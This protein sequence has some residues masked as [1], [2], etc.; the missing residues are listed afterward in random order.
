MNRAL[1]LLMALQGRGWLR[2]AGRSVRT[3]KG[4]VLVLVGL[5]VFAPW[6]LSVFLLPQPERS[7]VAPEDL[8]RYGPAVFLV[9]CLSTV[10]F[11]R[12]ERALYFSPAEV[13][14]LFCGPYTRRQLLAYKVVASTLVG[15]PT[16]LF[17]SLL[18]QVHARWYVAAFVGLFLTYLFF[19]LF[20]L[21]VNI[22]GITV[23]ARAYSAGRRV[24]L[25]G[26][27]LVLAVVLF[28]AARA[29]GPD[30]I[31]GLFDR[32]ED[33]P[34]WR[35]VATPLG[36]FVEAFLVEKGDWSSLA[37]YAS[38]S[39]GMVLALLVVVFLLDAHYL[40]SAA[41]ASERIYAQLQ[42]VRRGEAG[43]LSWR[44][45][46]GKPR[47]SLPSFP[48]WGGIGPVA[49]RQATTA[50]RSLGRLALLALVLGPILAGPLLADDGPRRADVGPYFILG[51]LG[52]L[53]ILMTTLVPFDFRG[54]L[55]RMEVLK[56]LPLAPW[57]LA[58]GQLV[59]PV[60]L[61]SA[62]QGLVL[63]AGFAATGRPDPL[64]IVGMAFTPAFNFLLFGLDNVLFLCF[65]SR[66]VASNPGDFQ[67]M[68]RNVL[69]LL[70]KVLLIVVA[71]ALAWLSGWLAY[72]AG[73]GLGVAFAA[74]WLAVALLAASLVPLLAFAFDRFDVARD[75]PA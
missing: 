66:V 47:L 19:Q 23:G 2:R 70:A 41:V 48:W 20:M 75:M 15:L 29:A 11:S 59:A 45:G 28:Q 21:A 9:Y 6:L 55:E 1:W 36:W 57:R 65:P 37:Q 4:A 17:L 14:F 68:G 30:G 42:R 44:G 25:V 50:L 22:V 18:F 10:L 54:D 71:L 16:T 46:S 69:F 31:R 32:V 51:I 56:T 53:T 63:L 74:A 26:L 33:S 60:L 58:V 24:V 43:G 8:R 38:L 12:G 13:N 61:V 5:L 3:V 62:V 40:E 27:G 52:W 67:A 72:L 7:T 64:L 35:A 49:W 73:G 34:A 39:A